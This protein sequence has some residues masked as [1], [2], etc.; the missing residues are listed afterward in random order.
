MHYGGNKKS[1]LIRRSL[2]TILP[3]AQMYQ[4]YILYF[5]IS[6]MLPVVTVVAVFPTVLSCVAV[7][8][9]TIVGLRVIVY[10]T[11]AAVCLRLQ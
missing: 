8:C 2:L 10:V 7:V 3:M 6:C 1:Q 5:A 9:Y 11:F 4:L